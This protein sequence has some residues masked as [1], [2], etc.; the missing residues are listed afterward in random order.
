[1]QPQRPARPDPHLRLEQLKIV[2]L[3]ITGALLATVSWLVVG[4]TVGSTQS[5]VEPTPVPLFAIPRQGDDDNELFNSGS[6]LFDGGTTTPVMRS[7][8][9]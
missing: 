5:T 8:G 6:T 4:H 1:M 3:S 9:S 2:V 7:H